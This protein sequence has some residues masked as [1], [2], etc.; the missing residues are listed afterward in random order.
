L[1]VANETDDRVDLSVAEA[2]DRIHV[3]EVPVVL[4]GSIADR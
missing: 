1:G 2:I 4:L 3:A